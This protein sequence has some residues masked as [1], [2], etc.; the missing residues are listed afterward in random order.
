MYAYFTREIVIHDADVAQIFYLFSFTLK[1]DTSALT[2]SWE[3]L[4]E[5]REE[6]FV[7]RRLD[8]DFLGNDSLG[9]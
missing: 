9:E 8:N 2:N 1:E 6:V 5:S 7:R 3:N 4:E